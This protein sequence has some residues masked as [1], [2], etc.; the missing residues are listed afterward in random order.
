LT[1]PAR[2]RFNPGVRLERAAWAVLLAAA[3]A[4]GTSACGSSKPATA[5]QHQTATTTS[6]APAAS[7]T[8]APAVPG[9][10]RAAA[11]ASRLAAAGYAVRTSAARFA[12]PGRGSF[13]TQRS[14][15]TGPS[16]PPPQATL[17][18]TKPIDDHRVAGLRRKLYAVDAAVSHQ[19][20]MATAA[21]TRR[22]QALVE[23]IQDQFRVEVAVYRSAAEAAADH[24]DA[25]Q[26]F[27]SPRN[28]VLVS[29]VARKGPV[30]Y[31]MTVGGEV[32]SRYDAAFRRLIDAGEGA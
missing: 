27:T 3:L 17:T 10:P 19:S 6:T 1:G 18:V 16:G 9:S 21:Q 26:P 4:A 2:R 22:I 30:V 12:T 11:I 32:G 7:P 5:P 24:G 31:R 13:D 25:Q 15:A 29:R 14:G 8:R 20:T 28:A 23:Q